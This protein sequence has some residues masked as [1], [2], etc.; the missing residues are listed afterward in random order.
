M[1]EKYL[2]MALMSQHTYAHSVRS[3]KIAT[4]YLPPPIVAE[5]Q[6]YLRWH[7]GGFPVD[8]AYLFMGSLQDIVK[9]NQKEFSKIVANLDS[10]GLERAKEIEL[11]TNAISY[12]MEAL[13][14]G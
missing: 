3:Y 10:I 11:E 6:Q 7:H 1:S 8:L 2:A 12:F 14:N 13:E 4:H 9:R 5:L